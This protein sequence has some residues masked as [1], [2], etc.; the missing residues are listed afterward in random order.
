M[1]RM[2]RMKETRILFL[3]S[4]SAIDARVRGLRTKMKAVKKATGA[5]YGREST[6]PVAAG[7]SPAGFSTMP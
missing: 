5:Q 3:P 1:T 7:V 2:T 4:P 6:D